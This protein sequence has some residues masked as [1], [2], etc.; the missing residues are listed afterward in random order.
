MISISKRL[1]ALTLCVPLIAGCAQKS[2]EIQGSYV[3]PLQYKSYSCRQLTEEGTRISQR[4]AEL[5]GVQDQKAKNDAGAVAVSLILW[6]AAF[7]IKGDKTTAAELARLKGELDA[8]EQSSIKRNCGITF[9][10]S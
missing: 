8:I 10:T 4:A 2:A 9:K 5:A 1:F 3:S 7:F 6:P